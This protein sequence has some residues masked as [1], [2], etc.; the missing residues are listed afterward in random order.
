MQTI[1]MTLISRRRFIEAASAA[2]VLHPLSSRGQDAA[3]K[4]KIK[5][6]LI[7][8]GG[9]GAWIADLFKQHGGYEFHAVADYFQPVAEK[10]G[11]ALGVDKTRCFSGL[12]GFR[13]VIDSGVEAVVLETPPYFLPEHAAAAVAAGLH[14]YMA[15]PVAV[16]VPG[17][18]TIEAAA[19]EA[20]KKQKV[21]LVDYQIPTDPINIEV[22]RRIKD[23]AFGPLLQVQSIGICNGFGDPPKGATL[24]GRLQN[25]V[26]V[27]DIALGCDYIGNFDIHAI[28]AAMWVIGERPVA[29]SGSSLIGRPDP[30]GDARDVCS[31]IYRYA[32]GVVHNHFGQ[33]LANQTPGAI[34]VIAHGANTHGQVDYYK[35]GFVLGGGELRF[36]GAVENL[37]AQGA[38]RNIATFHQN[39]SNGV[40]TNDT[41]RRSVDGCLACVL[42]REAAARGAELTMEQL[43]KENRKLQTDLTGLKA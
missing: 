41:V 11:T 13:K 9:R 24:E 8:A 6:G 38:V 7:G 17:C 21:F 15:K 19:A 28:D 33:G 23:P 22:V 10:A 35:E 1:P 42:G 39:V 3:A 20:T 16:D 2:A 34:R 40:F 31:V 43:L 14:V 4:L 36:K 18:L 5:I 37:Y 12:S 30:H 25:L 26:W 32:N 27:N 29:A